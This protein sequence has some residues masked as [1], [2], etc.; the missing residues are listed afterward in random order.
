MNR[1]I[2]LAVVFLAIP[3]PVF[4]QE[5]E[6]SKLVHAIQYRSSSCGNWQTECARLHGWQSPAWHQCMGQPGALRDCGARWGE[7]RPRGWSGSRSSRSDLCGN[8]QREC[9]RFYGWQSSAWH[10]CMNQPGALR[11]CGRVR[12]WGGQRTSRQDLCENWH[13]ECARLYGWRS[14]AWNACMG[15]PG[16][17]WDCQ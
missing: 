14:P 8:W 7:S 3:S 17:I 16:A 5:S 12:S 2:A 11:D 4:A 6:P 10:Q 15:Q 9:A 1:L 13:R